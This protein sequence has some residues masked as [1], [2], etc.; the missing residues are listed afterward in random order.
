MVGVL[1]ALVGEILRRQFYRNLAYLRDCRELET[2]H[3][4][5]WGRPLVGHLFLVEPVGEQLPY[6]RVLEYQCD[7]LLEPRHR[8]GRCGGSLEACIVIADLALVPGVA[9]PAG[10]RSQVVPVRGEPHAHVL[11]PPGIEAPVEVCGIVQKRNFVLRGHLECLL[12]KFVDVDVAL[13]FDLSQEFDVVQD[14]ATHA[15]EP[16]R[17]SEYLRT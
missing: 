10:L 13:T 2:A 9:I 7:E 15:L 11:E 3:V 17:V 14:E 6:H 12:C 8:S 5:A 1:G 4:V 16:S